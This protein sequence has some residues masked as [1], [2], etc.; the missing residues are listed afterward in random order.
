MATS[1]GFD[2]SAYSVRYLTFSWYLKSQSINNNT[3]TIGWSLTGAGGTT[4]RW[5]YAEQFKVK[6]NNQQ[7]YYSGSQIQL[8]NGTVVASGEYTI[9]HNADGTGSFNAYAEAAI[10]D[11]WVN[12]SGSGSWDLPTIQRASQP[13][14]NT[15]PQNSPN[16]NIGDTITIHMNR[17]SSS[18]THT[19]IMDLGIGEYTVATNV[20]D[21]C[22]LDTS[23][24]EIKESLYANSMNAKF[25]QNVIKVKTYNGTTLIGEK[26]C[27]YKANVTNSNPTFDVAYQDT[28]ASTIA[29]TNDNQQI[30]RNN[31]TLQI[32][33][34]NAEAKNYATLQRVTVTIEGGSVFSAISGSSVDINIGTLNLSKDTDITVTLLDSRGFTTTKTLTITV[35]DWSLPTAIITM[36]RVNN[37]YSETDI[38]VDA[39][40]SSLD[41]KNTIEIKYR[42]KKTTDQN[43]GNYSTLQDNVQSQFQADNLYEWNVQ[44]LVSD[45]IGSTTY[46]LQLGVGLPILFIDR[47]LRSLGVNCFPENSESLELNGDLVV[48]KTKMLNFSTTEKVVGTW[49]NDKP[50]YQKTIYLSS[51]PNATQQTYQTGIVNPEYCVNLFGMADNGFPLNLSR[52]NA[53]Q[54]GIGAFFDIQ[55]SNLTVECGTDRS[56]L[57]A[58]VTVQYTK[59]TD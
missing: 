42:I 58:Y 51:L 56:S 59:T 49:V 25:Y 1:G 52:P 40:Y 21:N 6:I 54:Y 33:V 4:T 39:N 17:A 16:F 43:W 13:S 34:T 41:S 29:I 19:V 2:T 10:F 57:S 11:S 46:N 22:T 20:T 38:K 12:V 45:A 27:Q 32:N 8:F 23:I 31:S 37:F 30:I 7:V 9:N 48:T 14:I 50:I 44:V 5:Y 15:Y 53:S 26:T 3:S 35:L 18:F 36:N 24:S 55:T 47:L 28:N